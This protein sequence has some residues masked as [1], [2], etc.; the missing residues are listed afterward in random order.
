M[1][2]AMASNDGLSGAARNI[3]EL[4]GRKNYYFVPFGQDDPEKK[5]T[6]PPA[7][8][9]GCRRS[10]ITQ[11]PLALFSNGLTS[12]FQYVVDAVPDRRGGGPA[13]NFQCLRTD[14]LAGAL[15]QFDLILNTVPALLG[16][17]PCS[18]PQVTTSCPSSR[19]SRARHTWR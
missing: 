9:R 2:V 8:A 13:E 15:G 3:G 16:P 4:L 11:I 10:R 6:A 19:S 18:R 14:A 17:P 5:P 1:V 7:P 12:F